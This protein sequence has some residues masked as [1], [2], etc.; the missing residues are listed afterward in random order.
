M[1]AEEEEAPPP[2]EVEEESPALEVEPVQISDLEAR[3]DVDVKNVVKALNRS[4]KQ[5]KT[6]NYKKADYVTHILRL[7]GTR[8]SKRQL[9]RMRKQELE[10]LLADLIDESME[11]YFPNMPTTTE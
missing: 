6:K 8:F 2:E 11:E 1:S 7:S 10:Q 9:T 3:K 5:A 4:E